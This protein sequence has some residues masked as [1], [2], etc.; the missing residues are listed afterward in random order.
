[1]AV[2]APLLAVAGGG[3]LVL[4]IMSRHPALVQRLVD[5][6][7]FERLRLLA[8]ELSAHLGQPMSRWRTAAMTAATA[9]V[10]VLY[11]LQALLVLYW[12]AH[13]PL[14]LGQALLVFTVSA[15]GM[16]LPSSPGSLGVHEAAVVAALGWLS[17][18]KAEALM[19]ALVTHAVQ[20]IPTTLA[21][22]LI[23]T[24]THLRLWPGN[25]PGGDL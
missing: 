13:L 25:A 2:L 17:V 24:R 14:S 4:F 6:I 10:W 5:L 8:G 21:A 18:P 12:V 19:A 16:A 20:Y 15:L 3:T 9:A 7:P 1:M 23:L 11:A 22:V